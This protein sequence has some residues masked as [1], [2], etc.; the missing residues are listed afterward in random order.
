MQDV[1]KEGFGH[2][3]RHQSSAA[4]VFERDHCRNLDPGLDFDFRE[5][6]WLALPKLW[7][8]VLKRSDTA[9]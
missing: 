8:Q 7:E 2:T 9:R 4:F 5:N 1:R 3:S 6:W